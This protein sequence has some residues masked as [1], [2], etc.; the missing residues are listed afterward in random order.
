MITWDAHHLTKW[1]EY[2]NKSRNWIYKNAMAGRRVQ[3]ATLL[4]TWL[5]LHS[6]DIHA[7]GKVRN[8]VL[9]PPQNVIH[10]VNDKSGPAPR[11]PGR[12]KAPEELDPEDCYPDTVIP[13]S[14]IKIKVDCYKEINADPQKV[15][16][17]F[18]SSNLATNPRFTA[19]RNAQNDGIESA[20]YDLGWRI[21]RQALEKANDGMAVGNYDNAY[22]CKAW[23][24]APPLWVD[25]YKGDDLDALLRQM[26]GEARQDENESESESDD[27]SI[28]RN[29]D[30]DL[31]MN[32]SDGDDEDASLF[33]PLRKKSSARAIAKAHS[34]RARTRAAKRKSKGVAEN[35]SKS[36]YKVRRVSSIERAM[37][38]RMT[39]LGDDDTVSALKHYSLSGTDKH[40]HR[41]KS[42]T[43]YR[44]VLWRKGNQWLRRGSVPLN[45]RYAHA[46]WNAIQFC[47]KEG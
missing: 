10:T 32:S 29:D 7:H 25:K 20:F 47:F 3:R 40:G 12:E 34:K 43:S 1:E 39:G 45:Q 36:S 22:H 26:K 18:I 9:D 6:P 41:R 31:D 33:L 16:A 46:M 23:R 4:A 28:M 38:Q 44:K 21:N 30:T 19:R 13:Y 11:I 27:V 5:D 42:M 37:L 15:V 24:M 35:S 8:R 17:N 2:L 14:T